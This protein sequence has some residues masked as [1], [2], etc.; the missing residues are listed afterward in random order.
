MARTI[1]ASTLQAL[2]ND[3]FRMCH[4]IDIDFG[5][6]LYLTDNAYNISYN[7][8]T[9]IAESYVLGIGS[10]NES[11]DLRVGNITLNIST[12]SSTVRDYLLQNDIINREAQFYRAVIDDDSGAIVGDPI[13]TFKGYISNFTMQDSGQ[14][15]SAT[16][17]IASHWADF[18]KK[19]GRFTN[20][21]SQQ[22]VFAGD[23]GMQFAANTVKNL[24]WGAS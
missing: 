10:S 16:I 20:D 7:S 2:E 12:V 17:A 4:L 8:N 15:S 14:K 18:E 22:N 6:T 24:R 3:G 5:T 9:Y 13:P 23:L 11:T 1:N 19:N 21:N